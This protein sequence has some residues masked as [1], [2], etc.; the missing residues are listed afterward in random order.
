MIVSRTPL[1]I[2]FVGGGTDLPAYCDEHGGAVISTAIDKWVRV[3]VSPRFEN[4][5]RVCYSQTEIVDSVEEVRHDL[6]REA[7]KRT[8]IPRGI[9][10][11]TLADVP[12]HGTGL[13]SSSA[14]TVGLL[15]ALYAF[16]GRA[17][18]VRT[19]AEEA[20]EIEIEV[21]GKPIGR[22]D[23]YACAV[24]GLNLI[25]FLPGGGG[26]DVSPIVAKRETVE[27][28][29]RSLLLFHTGVARGGDEILSKQ[30]AAIASG[31]VLTT[32]HAM[33]DMAYE[34]RD[35][36]S[37]GD[38]ESLGRILH[39]GWEAKQKVAAGTSSKDID[40]MYSRAME[41]GA[42]G[43]KILGAGGGGFLLMSVP[44]QK[45]LQ[46]RRALA[47]LRE[48]PYHFAAHGSQIAYLEQS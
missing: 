2:S 22:Q 46:I 7:M 42:L 26:V 30:S 35:L 39:R 40:E 10:I 9:D 1:R 38:V 25:E 34:M 13:G 37:E 5:I 29:Y 32:M 24:G 28:F 33:R 21:L 47:H 11:L 41:A 8:G 43:G 45:H 27:E 14:V 44:V 3:V 48:I 20:S 12:S 6:V 17:K 4:D 23:Q 19:L 15:N 31:D 36:F 16:Q 18:P